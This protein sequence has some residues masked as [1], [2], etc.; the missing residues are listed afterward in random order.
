MCIYILF[1]K[2]CDFNLQEPNLG[3]KMDTTKLRK[4]KSSYAFKYWKKL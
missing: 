2:S 3:T 1:F 4:N